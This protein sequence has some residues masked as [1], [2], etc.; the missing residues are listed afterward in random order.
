MAKCYYELY[1]QVI[2]LLNL[3]H[4]YKQAARGKR[5]QP[6]VAAFEYDLEYN[7]FDLECEL[8]YGGYQP[9]GY[10]NF[11]IQSPKRRVISAAPFRDRVV[12]HALMNKEIRSF[13]IEGANF[14]FLDGLS[15]AINHR[16]RV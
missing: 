10:R 12:H 7:L 16:A 11:V 1:L 6:A 15:P 14:G 4:A 13:Y 9:G 8:R 3:W 2:R 5:Y